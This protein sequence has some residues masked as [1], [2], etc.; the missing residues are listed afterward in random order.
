MASVTGDVRG[1]LGN[2]L[3]V[4]FTTLAYA[5]RT[6]RRPW[7]ARAAQYGA[8]SAYWDSLLSDVPIQ[9]ESAQIATV[10]KEPP[11]QIFAEIPSGADLLYGYFQS[12]LYFMTESESIIKELKLLE[13]RD[14]LRSRIGPGCN[15]SMH[16]RLGDYKRV[17]API[18]DLSYYQ[19]ALTAVASELGPATV[20][21]FFESE[22]IDQVESWIL[23]LRDQ[24]PRLEYRPV[25]SGERADWEDLLTMSLCDHHIIA[26]STFS[27]WGA[28]LNPSTKK[29]VACP[30]NWLG[31]PAVAAI[32]YPDN[33]IRI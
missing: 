29:Q 11:S 5:K 20:W 1:G 14:E 6:G 9:P 7:F 10:Y 8:R 30:A 4:V 16:F 22:D 32:I 23:Q 13:R 17:G 3:F 15:V 24:F 12:P 26:N 19:S 31:D 21:Y 25:Q 33:W 2:Q 27:W 28:F 18:L